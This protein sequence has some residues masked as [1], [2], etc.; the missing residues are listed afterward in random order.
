MYNIYKKH[1]ESESS[2]TTPDISTSSSESRYASDEPV[3]TANCK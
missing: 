2:G 3:F 1:S